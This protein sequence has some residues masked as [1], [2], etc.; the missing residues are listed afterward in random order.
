MIRGKLSR[1]AKNNLVYSYERSWEFSVNDLTTV[2]VEEGFVFKT[3][4]G[5]PLCTHISAC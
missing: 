5:E 1:Y 2:C 4:S 3:E